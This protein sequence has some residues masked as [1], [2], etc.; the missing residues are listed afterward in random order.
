MKGVVYEVTCFYFYYLVVNHPMKRRNELKEQSTGDCSDGADNDG[1]GSFFD[2]N[3]DG[4]TGA[5]DCS[6]DNEVSIE[7][8]SEISSEPSS[9]TSSEPSS[10]AS[11]EPTSEPS[12]EDVDNDGILVNED[13][14]DEDS[15]L[16]A[17]Q[18]DEDCD[19]ILSG[20]DCDDS[21]PTTVDD[22]DCDGFSSLIDCDD[23]NDTVYPNASDSWYDGVDSDCQGND[24]YD[25]DGDGYVEEQYASNSPLLSGDCNDEDGNINIGSSD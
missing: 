12:N 19:G 23:Y 1:D 3:D 20:D 4:C 10:E 15:T 9:E 17:I 14:D 18:L 22:M 7:P 13:C 2:C 11:T 8:S 5:P 25:Q 24:D 21:D 16:G 6:G